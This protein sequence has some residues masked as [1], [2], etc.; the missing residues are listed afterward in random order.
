MLHPTYPLLTERLS[1]RPFRPD[2]LDAFH[3]IQ[4]RPDEIGRAHV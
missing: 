2:D 1:L 4:S 3:D